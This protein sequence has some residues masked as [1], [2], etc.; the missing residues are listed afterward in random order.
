MNKK[1][2]LQKEVAIYLLRLQQ[3]TIDLSYNSDLLWALL[4]GL[5]I[6]G[7]DIWHYPTTL[8]WNNL[9]SEET[10]EPL[11]LEEII[12]NRLQRNDDL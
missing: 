3:V 4:A 11:R 6:T 10:L 8:L 1:W 2:W 12:I 5:T 9:R 7:Y